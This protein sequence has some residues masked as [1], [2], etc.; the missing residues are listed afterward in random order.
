VNLKTVDLRS[1][2]AYFSSAKGSLKYGDPVSLVGEK[3]SW[4]EVRSRDNPA[5][6]GWIA[7]SGLSARQVLQSGQRS[8]SAIEVALA[9]KGFNAEVE[10]NYR[11]R[12]ALDY[13]GI[14]RLEARKLSVDELLRFLTEGHLARG[15]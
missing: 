15:E 2:P 7:A 6:S 5:L 14:D 12:L 1:L 3:G 11:R 8:V 10:I 13:S 9:G 4:A